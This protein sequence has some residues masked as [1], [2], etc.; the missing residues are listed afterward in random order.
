MKI[1]PVEAE[2]TDKLDWGT[3][4]ELE[5][6]VA[7]SCALAELLL[8]KFI[9]A[10]SWEKGSK[11]KEYLDFGVQSLVRASTD[12]LRDAENK[13]N[14][15]ISQLK[16]AAPEKPPQKNKKRGVTES[17]I[18]QVTRRSTTHRIGGKP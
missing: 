3:V 14:S 13:V 11:F 2:K 8:D 16:Q 12:R 6:A 7:G 4:M 18:P 15:Y 9:Q 5:T 1:K 17:G 10:Q